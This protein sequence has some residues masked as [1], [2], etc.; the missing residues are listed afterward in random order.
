MLKMLKS[1]DANAHRQQVLRTQ[2]ELKAR[3]AKEQ[4][5]KSRQHLGEFLAKVNKIGD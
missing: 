4:L 2:H 5:L 1:A 3:Q